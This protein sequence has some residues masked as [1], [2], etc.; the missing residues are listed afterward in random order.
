MVSQ[1]LADE[2]FP[3]R[4]GSTEGRAQAAFTRAGAGAGESND[5]VLSVGLR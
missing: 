1:S 5:I 4:I 3:T 2:P